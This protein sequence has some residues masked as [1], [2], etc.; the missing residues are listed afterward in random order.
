MLVTSLKTRKTAFIKL[1][2]ILLCNKVGVDE[3]LQSPF[4]IWLILL[5][6]IC[7]QKSLVTGLEKSK[8]E[9]MRLGNS[10]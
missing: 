5:R 7:W 2:E 10:L 1:D 6:D 9:C 4:A 8:T 3:N